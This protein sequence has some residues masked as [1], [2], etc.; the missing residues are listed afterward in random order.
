V[1]RC[2]VVGLTLLLDAAPL[3]SGEEGILLGLDLLKR[4]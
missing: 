3:L 2:R 1:E 4:V